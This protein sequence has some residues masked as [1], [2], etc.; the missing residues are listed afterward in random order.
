MRDVTGTLN[1]GCVLYECGTWDTVTGSCLQSHI[2]NNTKV[3]LTEVG[4]WARVLRFVDFLQ[5]QKKK[6]SIRA[7]LNFFQH[8]LN[9]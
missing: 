1:L 3:L 8:I 2:V 9:F 5:D 7:I 6:M 4:K